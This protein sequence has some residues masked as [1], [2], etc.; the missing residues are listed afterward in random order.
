MSERIDRFQRRHRWAGFPIAVIYKYVDDSGSYLAALIAYYGIVSLFPLLLL[1]ATV[2]GFVLSGNPHLQ[3]EILT[4]AL[5]QFPVIGTQLDDPTHLGGGPGGLTIG[6]IGSVYGGLGVA[7]AAQYAM[8]T[9]WAV[10]KNNRP[11]PFKARGRSLLL[12]ATGGLAVLCTFALSVIGAGNAGSFGTVIRVVVLAGSVLLNAALAVLAMRIATARDLSTRDVLPGA[13]SAALLWQLLQTFSVIYVNHV[14][15]GSSDTNGVFALVLGM[16]AFLYLTG[17]A[18]VIS[19]EINVV[20][21]EHL[22]PRALLTPFTDNVDL[23]RGDRRA[24][25]KQAKAQRAK[26]FEEIDVEF[27]P[28]PE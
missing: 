9:A 17:V 25:T 13:I 11:N 3:S 10:P 8:N 15:R 16:L 14:V 12:L 28:P 5:N 6:I 1:S 21:A 27:N 26:G 19:V 4:S 7:Q 20:R 18:V 23:T 22:Y 2:L 24:Y